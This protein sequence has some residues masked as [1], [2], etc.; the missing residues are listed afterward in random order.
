MVVSKGSTTLAVIEALIVD[1]VEK[2]NLTAHFHKL[3]GYDTCRFFFHVTYVRHADCIRVLNHLKT[4]CRTPPPG[5]R[6][7]RSEDL[8]DVDSMPVGF[9][10]QYSINLRDVEV[11]FLVL[12]MYQQGQRTASAAQQVIAR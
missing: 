1:S 6:Y 11:V 7:T 5:F 3:L 8:P 12:D 9:K 2:C 4:T 10:A